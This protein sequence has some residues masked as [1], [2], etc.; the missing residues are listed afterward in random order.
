MKLAAKSFTK[1]QNKLLKRIV[2]SVLLFVLC[3]FV[4]ERFLAVRVLAFL[5]PYAVGGYDIVIKAVRNVG[6]KQIFDENL[7]MFIATVG[8]FA[9]GEFTEAVAVVLLYQIG[10]LFQSVAVSRSRKSIA[11]LMDIRPDYANVLT[12]DGSVQTVSPESVAI[13]TEILIKSGEKVPIDCMVL[14]GKSE[15]DTSSLTGESVPRS[16]GEGEFIISGSVNLSGSLRAKTVKSFGESTVSKI[17]ELTEQNASRKSKSEN[18]I[19]GFA[20]YYTPIVC[21]LALIMAVVPTLFIGNFVA[22]LKSA[23]VFLVVSC[24]CALVISVPLSFFCG[25]GSASK[26][27]ILIKGAG[28]VEKLA[29]VDTVLFDKTGTLTTGQFDV[30]HIKPADGV[31][32]ETL[33][34]FTALAEQLSTHPIAEALRRAYPVANTAVSATEFKTKQIIGKGVRSVVDGKTVHVGNAALMEEIGVSIPNVSKDGTALFTVI[35][36]VY[37]GV[38]FV[39]DRIKPDAKQAVCALRRAGVKKAVMLTGDKEKV[40]KAIAKEL[41][42]DAVH[43][44]LLPAEKVALAETYLESPD[45][46]GFV[47]YVG[48][49][50]NDAP[51]LVRADVGIAMGALGSDAAI[52]AADVVLMDDKPSKIAQAFEISR[53]T[54]RIVRQNVVFALGVKIGVMLLSAA[55]FSSMWLAIFADVGVSVIAIL[56]ALRL[57]RFRE[58]VAFGKKLRAAKRRS[59]FRDL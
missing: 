1:K 23:L 51:V 16:V 40:G 15:L 42:L 14:D 43:C 38:I 4:P 11:A 47:A 33:L 34:C 3:L 8:A 46:K 12:E 26:H 13:G 55:C 53:K 22:H 48:D 17:L 5:V 37:S 49:G 39:S 56:N 24:P 7:L 54:M 30:T 10:E 25:I 45:K 58:T 57:L 19:T 36:G 52:E 32:A 35:D 31:D 28:F 6:N 27:G 29:R 59:G 20:R 21:A 50:I 18:F 9:L 44:E 2:L 41:S